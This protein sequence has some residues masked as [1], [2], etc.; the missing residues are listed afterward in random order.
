MWCWR[1]GGSS[2]RAGGCPQAFCVRRGAVRSRQRCRL[3]PLPRLGPSFGYPGGWYPP[4]PPGV[5]TGSPVVTLCRLARG[6]FA[7][8]ARCGWPFLF[9]VSAPS[10][11][12]AA[13]PAR[14]HCRCA[15][16]SARRAGTCPPCRQHRH[17]PAPFYIR[18]ACGP[19]PTPAWVGSVLW[20]APRP[21]PPRAGLRAASRAPFGLFVLGFSPHCLN[22]LLAL[23]MR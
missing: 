7:T 9:G 13:A 12:P 18:G 3:A 15:A 20:L 19:R 6:G 8:A 5:A 22:S 10:A 1:E 23:V 16:A 21:S 4:W 11:T 17:P 14:G 2:R